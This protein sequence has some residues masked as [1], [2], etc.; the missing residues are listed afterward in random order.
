MVSV[1][2]DVAS[3]VPAYSQG[4]SERPSSLQGLAGSWLS[5]NTLAFPTV[6]W[7]NQVT[8]A[9]QMDPR[10]GPESRADRPKF[11]DRESNTAL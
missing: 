3:G 1:V 7:P 5:V 6:S 8:V 10:T 11:K 2:E 9:R 4:R